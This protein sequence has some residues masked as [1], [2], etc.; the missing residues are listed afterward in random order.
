MTTDF[1][2][3]WIEIETSDGEIHRQE[4]SA[5]LAGLSTEI[6]EFSRMTYL[7]QERILLLLHQSG[8]EL[9]VEVFD[10][11]ISDEVRRAGRPSVYLDQNIWIRLAQIQSGANHVP[12]TERVAGLE[13]IAAAEAKE[14][15]LPLSSAH[16]VETARAGGKWRRDLAPL[17]AR[18]SRGWVMRDP[19]LVRNDE[20]ASALTGVP[21][22]PQATITLNSRQRSEAFANSSTVEQYSHFP[23]D[24]AILIDTLSLI[25]AVFSVLVEDDRSESEEGV[26]TAAAWAESFERLANQ[27]ANDSKAR[28]QIRKVAY[29]RY[30]TDLGSDLGR[31]IMHAGLDQNELKNWFQ[32]A[33][34][35]TIPKL[36]YQGRIL[37]LFERRLRNA[38]EPW[39]GNDL[40]DMMYLGLAATACEFV[41]GERKTCHH[42]REIGKARK[43]GASI[44][45]SIADFWK[46]F[47]VG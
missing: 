16:W 15:I 34:P 43:D 39:D 9:E 17:M 26:R 11:L 22:T 14:I 19:L 41:V 44:F 21:L 27:L 23:L 42:L 24:V 18:L 1:S 35:E 6:D 29:L 30:M 4:D 13:L 37:Q 12:E 36:P 38:A 25:G 10:P 28:A 40:N 8:F 46:A 3:G 20:L 31:A 47:R 32:N 45:S 5:I 2:E 7:I 33:A